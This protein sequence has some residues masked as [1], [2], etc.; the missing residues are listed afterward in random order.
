MVGF[1]ADFGTLLWFET[2]LLL[3]SII[4]VVLIF[5]LLLK[6]TIIWVVSYRNWRFWTI[7][8]TTKD[9]GMDF[10]HFEAIYYCG[11]TTSCSLLSLLSW[12]IFSVELLPPLLPPFF[13]HLRIVFVL[14]LAIPKLL[15]WENL[16]VNCFLCLCG[17]WLG[18]ICPY[19]YCCSTKSV[20]SGNKFSFGNFDCV[21]GPWC[22]FLICCSGPEVH[23]TQC[24]ELQDFVNNIYSKLAPDLCSSVELAC[25]KGASNCMAF[26]FTS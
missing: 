17:W 26:L 22:Y 2:L 8:F 13:N 21:S 11:V 23:A 7:L 20:F 18:L 6:A 4:L 16:N 25:E 24:N 5:I 19:C 12:P 15:G 3:G 1:T 10:R 14:H 9:A